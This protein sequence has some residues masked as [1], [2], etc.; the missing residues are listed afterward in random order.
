MQTWIYQFDAEEEGFSLSFFQ[1][2]AQSQY[3]IKYTYLFSEWY[4]Y[5]I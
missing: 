1:K 3:E 2:M 5:E 4:Y